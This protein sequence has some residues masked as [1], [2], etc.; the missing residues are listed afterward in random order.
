MNSLYNCLDVREHKIGYS[1]TDAVWQVIH[2]IDS[3]N[4]I[5]LPPGCGLTNAAQYVLSLH[6]NTYISV[7]YKPNSG[8]IAPAMSM[9]SQPIIATLSNLSSPPQPLCLTEKHM[10]QHSPN[11]SSCEWKNRDDE[12]RFSLL[13]SESSVPANF[14]FYHF[15]NDKNVRTCASCSR[16]INGL[17]ALCSSMARVV[18]FVLFSKLQARCAQLIVKIVREA[19]LELLIW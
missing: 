19:E 11:A 17:Q 10:A 9:Y 14:A 6:C 3:S 15:F 2:C 7:A 16:V 1:T 5:L 13:H 8:V 12:S 4:R 18:I